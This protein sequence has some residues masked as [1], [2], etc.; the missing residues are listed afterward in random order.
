M[1]NSALTP[2]LVTGAHRSGTTWVGRM[3]AADALTAYISEPLNVL[4]RPGVFRAR[5]SH[6]YQYICDENGSEFL[7]AFR[8]LL[9]F[10]YHLWAEIRSIRSLKDFLRMG[11]DFKI[12]SDAL[13][14]GQRALIKDP[15][16]VFSVPWFVKNLNCKVV[17]VVRHPA[18]FA[19]SLQ[20]LNWP[21]DFQHLLDQPLLMRD[22][23]EPYRDEMQSTKPDD[24]FG[25]AALLW[26]MV[27]RSVQSTL[28]HGVPS[29]DGPRELDP[30]FILVRHEDLARDPVVGYRA[31]YASLGLDFTPR[32]EKTILNS[33]SSDNP[34]ELPRRKTHSIRLDSLAS[35]DSWKKRLTAEE[36][37]RVHR[38][39]EDVSHI[40]YSDQ[41]W[42]L[43]GNE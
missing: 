15:F 2:I 14:H 19:S 23:L 20:R 42:G 34:A 17:V 24:I 18:A 40:Y 22:H 25:Q 1:D 12:F 36:I 30:G 21:F 43:T 28:R 27:Y 7:P 10:D 9:D 31:L 37:R 6:W 39:T 11:R 8:E 13:M 33:S 41:D 16:A 3:L 26:K 38:I 4:H 5:V 32:V 35:M 29:Q